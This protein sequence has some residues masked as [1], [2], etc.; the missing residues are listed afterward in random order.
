MDANLSDQEE[1]LL[2][3]TFGPVIKARL[4]EGDLEGAMALKR[5]ELKILHP[6][7]QV[8]WANTAAGRRVAARDS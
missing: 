3:Q 5:L 6:S 2:A 4:R 7:P 8:D 1:R